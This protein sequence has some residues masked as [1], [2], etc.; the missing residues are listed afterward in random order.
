[1]QP[2]PDL[3][4]LLLPTKK[5]KSSISYDQKERTRSR[6]SDEIQLLPENLKDLSEPEI[7]NVKIV[8]TK[9]GEI[10]FVPSIIFDLVQSLNTSL[11]L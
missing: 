7:I 10:R 4:R 6:L 9:L 2:D 3:E 8:R 11:P 5:S 1:M